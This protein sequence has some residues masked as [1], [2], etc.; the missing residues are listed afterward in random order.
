MSELENKLNDLSEQ[1][2]TETLKDLKAQ[3]DLMGIKYPANANLKK[4]VELID[5]HKKNLEKENTEAETTS[6]QIT[7]QKPRINKIGD[8]MD[9]ALKLVRVRVTVNNPSK[10][11]REGEIISAGNAVIGFVSK[12]IPY[13]PAFYE[14]GYHI[15]KI[16]LDA[17]MEMKHTRY[18]KKK[19]RFNATMDDYD[20]AR[21]VPDFTIEV[22]PPLTEQELKE[23]AEYQQAN[24]TVEDK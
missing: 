18:P 19:D 2:S 23:L 15:P 1:E 12:F 9:E 7:S 4:M 13:Q 10:Q 22:L 20:N 11:S 24:R 16:I 6:N 21:L 3:A 14:H 5:E 8:I 17:M